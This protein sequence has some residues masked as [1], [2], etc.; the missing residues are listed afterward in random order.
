[1]G[2]FSER[3]KELRIE[4]GMTQAAVAQ[5]TGFSQNTIAQWE[6]EDRAPNVNSI[7]LLAEF[8]GVTVGY[9]LGVED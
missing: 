4:G 2:R 5:G 6:N 1:M 3:L 9:L 8:F 7:V